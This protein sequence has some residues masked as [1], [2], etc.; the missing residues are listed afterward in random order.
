LRWASRYGHVEIVKL[1]LSAGADAHAKNDYALQWASRYG[2]V[3]IVKLLLSAGADVHA[4]NDYALRWAS[5]EGQAEVVKLLLTA[6]ADVHAENNAAFRWA[7]ENEH[8]EVVNLLKQWMEE[9]H[10][11]LKEDTT[12]KYR[13]D[14]AWVHKNFKGNIFKFNITGTQYGALKMLCTLADNDVITVSGDILSYLK[15]MEEQE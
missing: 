1:L 2:L 4:G 9:K 14:L 11:P 6:G 8:V 12:L 3:E 7:S 10:T 15:E 13:I 5:G